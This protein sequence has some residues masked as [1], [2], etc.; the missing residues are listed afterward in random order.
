MKHLS[1]ALVL[2]LFSLVACAVEPAQD[3]TAEQPAV[4]AAQEQALLEVPASLTHAATQAGCA[5]VF[6]CEFSCQFGGARNVLVQRC[7]DVETV[8]QSRPCGEECF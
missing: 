3:T 2:S 8:V 4:S 7:G 1:K 6:Q 5:L